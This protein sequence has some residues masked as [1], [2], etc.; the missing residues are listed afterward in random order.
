M[1]RYLLITIFSI[2]ALTFFRAIMGVVQKAVVNEVKSAMGGQDQPAPA[3]QQQ[4]GKSGPAATTLRKCANCGTYKPEGVMNRYGSG[5][6]TVFFC[7]ADCQ[8]KANA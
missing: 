7:S 2:L 5:D 4:P 8:K 1:I 3:Q 6:K